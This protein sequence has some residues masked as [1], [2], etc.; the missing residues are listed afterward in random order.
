MLSASCESLTCVS[1]QRSIVGVPL[2]SARGN[3][4]KLC[5]PWWCPSESNTSSP[6]RITATAAARPGCPGAWRPAK[7]CFPSR[8]CLRVGESEKKLPL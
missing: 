8:V 3:F 2:S 6:V 7:A 1:C 5:E 4:F